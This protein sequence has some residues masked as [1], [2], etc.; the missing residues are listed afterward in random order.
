M[1]PHQP[2]PLCGRCL[3]R[4]WEWVSGFTVRQWL[5]A[6]YTYRVR[7]FLQRLFDQRISINDHLPA[8]SPAPTPKPAG[9]PM[10]PRTVTA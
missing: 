9:V 3:G 2:T 8:H 10:R 6:A 4:A 5:G 1:L 7:R